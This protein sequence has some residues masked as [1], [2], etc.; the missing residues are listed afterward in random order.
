MFA[1]LSRL[2]IPPDRIDDGIEMV[3]EELVPA[4]LPARGALYGC[5]MAEREHGEV[6]SVTCWSDGEAVNDWLTETGPLRAGITDALGAI[7]FD[8]EEVRVHGIETFARR[9]PAQVATRAVFVDGLPGT[10][11]PAVVDA[12]FAAT[13]EEHRASPGF[14]TA[15]W[16]SNPVTG[17][18]VGLTAWEDELAID[19]NEPVNRT[20]R[21]LLERELG[22]RCWAVHRY[23]AV[24]AAATTIGTVDLRDGTSAAQPAPATTD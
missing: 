12:L 7:V 18:G 16:L 13:M 21:K 15:L 8:T 17:T 6:L 14:H 10:T 11:D 19:R 24:Q 22:C 2:R 3:S 5:W 9:R 1:R 20:R 4:F 23:E